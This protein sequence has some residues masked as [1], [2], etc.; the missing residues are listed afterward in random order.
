[1]VSPAE[2]SSLPS[3]SE[4]M[5]IFFCL[6]FGPAATWMACSILITLRNRVA[7]F[8]ALGSLFIAY[9]GSKG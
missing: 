3:L 6:R 7:Q 5:I 9:Y 2:S 1:M 4:L 8:Q